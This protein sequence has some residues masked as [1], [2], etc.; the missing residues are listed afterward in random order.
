MGCRTSDDPPGEAPRHRDVGWAVEL[1]LS[2]LAANVASAAIHGDNPVTDLFAFRQ[3][4]TAFSAACR[5]VREQTD[6]DDVDLVRGRDWSSEVPYYCRRRALALPDSWTQWVSLRH[7]AE[8]LEP[9]RPYRLRA[10]VVHNPAYYRLWYPTF[11]PVLLSC[12]LRRVLRYAD[13]AYEVLLLRPVRG[14]G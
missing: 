14:D 9:L 5:A 2:C 6:P 8:C 13:D 7:L 10:L 1:F 3:T 4:Q 12:G 11:D